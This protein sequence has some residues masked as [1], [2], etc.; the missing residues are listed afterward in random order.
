M[1]VRHAGALV[2]G[3]GWVGPRGFF[4]SDVMHTEFCK[5]WVHIGVGGWGSRGQSFSRW[6]RKALK[7]GDSGTKIRGTISRRRLWRALQHTVWVIIPE[8]RRNT[9]AYIHT[10]VT[11][12]LPPPPTTFFSYLIA[13]FPFLG[14][15][16]SQMVHLIPYDIDP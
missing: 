7:M 12:R 15:Y 6:S 10:F 13:T 14:L 1:Q 4:K 5:F 16:L 3:F 11:Y 2:V 9:A 8:Y